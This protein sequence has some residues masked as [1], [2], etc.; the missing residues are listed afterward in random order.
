LKVSDSSWNLGEKVHDSATFK[1]LEQQ[2]LERL[3]ASAA[4]PYLKGLQELFVNFWG[5]WIWV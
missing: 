5:E 2:L 3:F 1:G 4:E